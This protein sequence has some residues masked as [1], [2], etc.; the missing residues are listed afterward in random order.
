MKV[1][2]ALEWVPVDSG[3]FTSAA[4]RQNARQLYLRFQD[5]DIYRYFECPAMVYEEFMAS[6]SKSRYFSQHIRSRFRDERVRRGKITGGKQENLPS[7]A[8][9]LAASVLL[10]KAGRRS[11]A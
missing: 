7:L 11:D 2:S 8:E 1:V 4:Y 6:E 10:A 3:L 5:G 9:Q